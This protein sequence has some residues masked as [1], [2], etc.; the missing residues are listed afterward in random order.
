MA[1][2]GDFQYEIYLQGAAGQRPALPI[3]HDELE[4]AASEVMTPEGRGYV[5]G[6]AGCEQTVR[7]NR[8]AF[9]RWRIV[10]RMLRGVAERD[11][12]TT[13]LG[14][15]M[16]AP[17]LLA[18]VGVLGVLH[19][20]GELAVARGAAGLGVPMVLS[21]LGSVPMEDVAD[22]LGETPRWFQ[23]YWP[24]N[25]DVAASL[26]QR[27]A[28]AGFGALVVT[29][30]T[31]VLAWRPRDLALGYLP[32]LQ[33][34]GLANYFTDPAFR[35]GLAKPPEEDPQAAVGHWIAM[36]GSLALTWDDLAW[37]RSVS[38][39]PILLKGILHPDDARRA[40]DCGVSGLVVSNHGGR[41]VDGAAAALDCLPGVVSAAGDLPVLLDSGVRT[42]S[43]VIKAL[44]LGA[45]AVLL[46]RPYVYGLALAGADGVRHVLRCL[47]ADL[48]L[49]CAL[50]GLRRV[51]DI[52]TGTV[53][54]RP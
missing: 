4:R 27:A 41:Q 6:G 46:G 49:S 12:S 32:F 51:A 23:L 8:E 39:L 38:T 5:A 7:A 14:T 29:V 34:Q 17:V 2:F 44:A 1:H 40:V 3:T 47:L 21:T 53:V 11:L 54:A 28:K 36:F 52:D 9:G 15:R 45:R 13:V 22:A 16:P 31:G 18:P 20:D 30:D 25:R 43:D 26:V 24:S 37:L 10:P 19:S 42:G 48:D 50:S 35:A 33:A